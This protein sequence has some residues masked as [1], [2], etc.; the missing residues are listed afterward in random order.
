MERNQQQHLLVRA[1]AHLEMSRYAVDQ[2]HAAFLVGALFALF[3][4]SPVARRTGTIVLV[5]SIILNL[6]ALIQTWLARRIVKRL[7]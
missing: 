6:F 2:A 4:E 3:F 7:R 1:R 5:A